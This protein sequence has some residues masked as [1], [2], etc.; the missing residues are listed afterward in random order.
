MRNSTV[1]CPR[2]AASDTVRESTEIAAEIVQESLPLFNL[3]K[4]Q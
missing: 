3:S 4:K 2:R 1:V